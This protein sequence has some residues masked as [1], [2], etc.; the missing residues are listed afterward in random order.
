MDKEKE[1][2]I[3][4]TAEQKVIYDF[5]VLKAYAE[6]GNEDDSYDASEKIGT[7]WTIFHQFG[8]DINEITKEMFADDVVDNYDKL[9]EAGATIDLSE[10][11]PKLTAECVLR[12]LDFLYKKGIRANAAFDAILEDDPDVALERKMEEWLKDGV[13]AD[14]VYEAFKETIYKKDVEESLQD[15]G[16]LKNY[17]ALNPAIY[18]DFINSHYFY[19]W[20]HGP[21]KLLERMNCGMD[22]RKFWDCLHFRSFV[23]SLE[24]YYIHGDMAERVRV[25]VEDYLK[26]RMNIEE[27]AKKMV[28][29]FEYQC[30]GEVYYVL[31]ENGGAEY[32]DA[33]KICAWISPHCFTKKVIGLPR[34]EVLKTM[35][36]C[37]VKFINRLFGF[38][39]W[40]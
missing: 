32:L 29:E 31:L 38:Y 36:K 8:V 27:L 26:A 14:K 13:S 23:Y 28:D 6:N 15:I 34:K 1:C 18:P 19:I 11:L 7:L 9:I 37:K 10:E 16:L 4:M 2:I 20:E 12:N 5:A 17:G 22:F 40:F 30:F 24:K 3:A 21:N 39:G 25:F 35:R 33:D